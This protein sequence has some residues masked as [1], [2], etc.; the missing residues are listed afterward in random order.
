MRGYAWSI[1]K[2]VEEAAKL[3]GCTY[4]Q[5]LFRI[6]FPLLLPGIAAIGV[7]SF[8]FS[9]GEFFF[10]MILAMSYNVR[11]LPVIVASS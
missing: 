5:I 7:I 3:N 9:W 10:T 4:L 2:E 8:I 11:K 6:V 1:T